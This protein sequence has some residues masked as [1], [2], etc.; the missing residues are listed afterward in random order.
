MNRGQAPLFAE[1]ILPVAPKWSAG[2]MNPLI[3][4]SGA[5]NEGVL[6]LTNQTVCCRVLLLASYL[7]PFI[8]ISS[9]SKISVA[10]GPIMPPAPLSP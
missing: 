1:G 3:P 5:M 4:I 2:K 10:F 8:E 6:I 9:T 7:S